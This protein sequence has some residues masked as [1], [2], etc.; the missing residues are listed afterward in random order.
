MPCVQIDWSIRDSMF[1]S[2]RLHDLVHI[3]SIFCLFVHGRLVNRKLLSMWDVTIWRDSLWQSIPV[4]W[5]C[6]R[7]QG[8]LHLRLTLSKFF[9][10]FHFFGNLLRTDDDYEADCNN[11]KAWVQINLV[12]FLS[13]EHIHC[14]NNGLLKPRKPIM[15]VSQ[16]IKQVKFWIGLDFPEDQWYSC[17]GPKDSTSVSHRDFCNM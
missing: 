11:T 15:Q 7:A 6:S 10:F 8:N 3:M 2:K 13:Q 14:A 12:E 4:F 1:L 16:T 5:I 17:V 9:R